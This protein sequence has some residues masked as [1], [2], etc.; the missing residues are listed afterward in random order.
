MNEKKTLCSLSPGQSGV[1][2]GISESCPIHGRLYEL[3]FMKGERAYC[4]F[5]GPLGDP[6]AYS[7]GG[8]V[9]A[10]RKNDARYVYLEG[11]ETKWD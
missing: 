6:T 11:D 4:L 2:N 10:L 3:G 5:S 7:A 8:A 9:I 1:I